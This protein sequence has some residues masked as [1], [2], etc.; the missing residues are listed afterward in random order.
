MEKNWRRK[1][2]NR[3]FINYRFRNNSNYT[4]AVSATDAAIHKEICGSDTTA[5]IIWNEEMEDIIKIVKSL[6]N[7]DY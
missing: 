7:L 6:E 5:L 2:K 4:T 1:T 3:N